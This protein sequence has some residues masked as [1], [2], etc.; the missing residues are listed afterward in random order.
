MLTICAVAKPFAG[1]IGVIQRN[2]ITS[3]TKLEPKPEIILFGTEAGTAE[4]A[5]ELGLTHVAEV[6]RNRHGTPLLADILASA[7]KHG[8]GEVFAYVNA[9]IILPREFT[10]GVERARSRFGKFLAVGRRTNLEV[11]EALEFSEAWEEKLRERMRAEGQLE[12]HT[13]IDFFVF[14]R[15]T[16]REVPPLAIGRVWFDQWCI[17]YARKKGLAVVDLTRF[18]PIAHQLHDYNHV[19]GG[20]EQGTYG[21]VEA[22]ENLKYYGERPHAFTILSATHVMTEEGEIR[23][24]FWRREA[25]AV[26]NLLWEVFVHR[27]LGVRK[28]L[29]LSR[30]A[31]A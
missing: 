18:A 11:R 28:R 22:D 25:A 2:A 21:G 3:W 10:G 7:E 19:A 4:I 23:R 9:D 24:V 20:R 31:G 1:H 16:Y 27:T 13:G 15:G 14:P 17:K 12:S 5:R 6:A 8:S 29:G 26:K 30:R